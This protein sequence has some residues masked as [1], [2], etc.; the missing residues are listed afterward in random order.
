MVRKGDYQATLD[1]LS[2]RPYIYKILK[3]E[4]FRAGDAM[5]LANKIMRDDDPLD[6]RDLIVK[7]SRWLWADCSTERRQ[8]VE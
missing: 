5:S 7:S 2:V 3:Q 6:L 4:A 1:L 8:H